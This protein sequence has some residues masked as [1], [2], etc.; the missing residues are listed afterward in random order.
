M[1]NLL[2]I[3]PTIVLQKIDEKKKELEKIEQLTEGGKRPY[4]EFENWRNTVS[5]ML[6]EC[7]SLRSMSSEFLTDTHSFINKFSK[8]ESAKNLKVALDSSK[9]YLLRLKSEIHSGK[10]MSEENKDNS[11]STFTALI[12]I[13]RI[14]RNFHKHIETMYQAEV[15]GNG[16]IA[17]EDL[18][19][20]KIGNEYD[21]QRILYSLIRPIFPEARLEAVDDAGYNSVRYDLVIAEY[22]VVIEVKCTRENMTE[23]KLT[24][25]LGSDAFHYRANHLFLFIFD[26]VK[27]IKNMDAFEKSFNKKKIDVGKEIETF[28]I[29]EV[30]F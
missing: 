17:K 10:Y 9:S 11:I 4:Q 21:V 20:I 14:L 26:R 19:R 15:H 28:V 7:F 22:D 2:L 16:K 13:R 5:R 23:R 6:E 8:V 18:A 12:I 24:E 3:D 1:D 25:E 27:M 29:Q 30:L